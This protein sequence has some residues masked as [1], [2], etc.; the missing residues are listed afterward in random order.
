M[1]GFSKIIKT[2]LGMLWGWSK[3]FWK[4][5]TSYFVM[6][7]FW[8]PSGYHLGY[9]E[10]HEIDSYFAKIRKFVGFQ[11]KIALYH[12]TPWY[13]KVFF[14]KSMMFKVFK[15]LLQLIIP[16]F[17]QFLRLYG[18]HLNLKIEKTHFLK[19]QEK[20]G[21][22]FVVNCSIMN[23]RFRWMRSTQWS[24]Y[25]PSFEWYPKLPSFSF[26]SIFKSV[27]FFETHNF[28][29][30]SEKVFSMAPKISEISI[31]KKFDFWSF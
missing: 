26:L 29:L 3:R 6:I 5:Q 2:D 25:R 20:I 28:F 16:L 7:K 10:I 31:I 24:F 9:H 17:N 13:P 23:W 8:V 19:Y 18:K 15:T 22:N 14:S 1:I 11:S 27:T 30:M 12:G 21:R 4:L